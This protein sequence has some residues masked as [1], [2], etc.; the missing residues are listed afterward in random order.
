[1]RPLVVAGLLAG[2]LGLGRAPGTVTDLSVTGVTDTV[3]VLTWTGIAS[4]D[5]LPAHYDVRWAP[6]AGFAWW[7]ALVTPARVVDG[8]RAA[9]GEKLTTTV[10]GLKPLTA[11]TFQLVA[12][13]GTL[14]VNAAFGALSNVTTATTLATPP[15]QPPPPPPPPVPAS[16]QINAPSL[17]LYPN[18]A[19]ALHATVRDAAG[20]ILATPVVWT[21]SNALVAIV[22]STG[23]VT[24]RGLGVDTITAAAGLARSRSIVTVEA[25]PPPPPRPLLVCGV[26]PPPVGCGMSIANWSLLGV[27]PT[28]QTYGP[29]FILD[30]LGYKFKTVRVV[31]TDTTP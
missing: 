5:T 17:T 26:S 30:S 6:A 9:G 22:D 15:P 4:G 27:R 31:V 29:W 11:Y 20:A 19:T 1:M 12:Y 23:L 24:A 10:R 7:L 25:P 21:T 28:N 16:V 3:A 18:G 14:N 13:T 2:A 8:S